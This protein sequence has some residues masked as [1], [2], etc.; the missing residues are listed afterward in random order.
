M[1]YFSDNKV[2]DAVFEGGGI[3]AFAFAGAIKVMEDYGYSWRNLAG[4][5][6][7]SIIAAL[8]AAG[9]NSQEIKSIMKETDFK[10]FMDIN[11][12]CIPKI[13]NLLNLILKNGIYQGDYLKAWMDKLLLRKIKNPI[14]DKVT[15]KDLIIPNEKGVLLNNPK[16]KKKY[17]LHLMAS[18]ITRGRLMILPEDIADYGVNPEDFEV[19]L[20][21]RMSCSIPFYFKP[22][23]FKNQVNKKK[24]VIVDGG[25]LSNYPVWLFDVNGVPKY[26]T[27]G[28]RL[29]GNRSTYDHGEINNLIDFTKGIVKTMFEAQDDTHIKQIDYL[30]TIKIDSLNFN[31][32]DFNISKESLL[33]LYSSGEKSAKEFIDHWKSNYAAHRVLRKNYT[34]PYEV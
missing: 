28:F 13:H 1:N 4:T 19:S 32:V 29:N 26:P 17:K 12:L 20:A 6:G 25:V 2:A 3:K 11:K 21:I 16:Y 5:S 22:V 23:Y 10:S 8:L 34:I 14:K 24:S 31:A 30:R 9:Y 27:L 7:G 18:D 15:F 33:K